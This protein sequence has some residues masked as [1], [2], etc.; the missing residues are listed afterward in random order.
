MPSTTSFTSTSETERRPRTRLV[1]GQISYVN[2]QPFYPLLGEHRLIPTPPRE[3]G[4]MAAKGEIDAGILATADFLACEDRY[5]PI[6]GLGIANREEVRSILL[7]SR[8]PI[9]D[10]DGKTIGVTEETSTSVRLL[11]VLLELRYGLVPAGYARGFRE[12]ADAF[13]VIGNEA[14]AQNLRPSPGFPHRYDLASEWWAWKGLPF[15]FALWAVRRSLPDGVKQ[16]FADLLERSFTLGMTQIDEIAAE[17]AGGL[18]SA[19]ALASYLR[20]FHYR[21]GAE[22]ME[23]LGEFRRLVHEQGWLAPM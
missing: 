18:G 23:G 3:L 16:D 15:V 6:A 4:R 1:V 22:E 2:S 9:E 8:V 21:L 17:L 10:L 19:E 11:R 7:A 5:E 14:L 20:N 12:S 13:L